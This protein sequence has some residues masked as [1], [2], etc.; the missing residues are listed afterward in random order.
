MALQKLLDRNELQRLQDEFCNVSGVSAYCLDHE[1]AKLTRISG[2]DRYLHSLPERLA[3]ERVIGDESLEDLAT[4]PLDGRKLVTALAI[5]ARGEKELYWILFKPEEMDES[6]Y[7]QAVELLRDASISFLQGKLLTFGAQADAIRDEAE[8]KRGSRN[9]KMIQAIARIIQLLDSQ[10]SIESLMNEWLGTVANFMELDTAQI[11]KLQEHEKFMDVICEWRKQGL[12]SFF[13]R[14]SRVATYSFLRREEPVVINADTVTDPEFHEVFSIGVK[15]MMLYPVGPRDSHLVVALNHRRVH[16]FDEEEEKFAADAVKILNNVLVRRIQRNSLTS[17]YVSMESVLDGINTCIMVR[18]EA[19]RKMIYV[20]HMFESTFPVEMKEED[21]DWLTEKPKE[22]AGKAKKAPKKAQEKAR[23]IDEIFEVY[24]RREVYYE[25]KERWY[26][27]TETNLHWVDGNV[28]RMYSLY[29]ITEKKQYQGRIQQQAYTDFL[30]GLYNRLCCE[31]DLADQIE[32]AISK[33]KTGALLY[34]DLDD[35]KHINDGL[36]HQYGDALL[37]AIAHAFQRIPGIENSCYR[38]G[39]DEFVIVVSPESY[40]RL[41]IILQDIQQIFSKPWFLKDSDYYCTMSMGAVTFP[42][43]G[44]SVTDLVKKADIAMY[45]AKKAGKNRVQ[46]Y[47]NGT[48]ST[49][50]RRL[51]MVKNMRE[52]TAKNFGEFE[53]YYQPIM[54]VDGG[55]AKCSGAEA[56]IRWN[57]TSLGFLSSTEFIPLAEY[58]GLINPIGNH[59][60]IEACKQCKE[61]N[62]KGYDFSVNVNLSVIQLLQNDIVD[63]VENALKQTKLDPSHLVLEVTE[64]LAINDMERMKRILDQIRKLGVKIALDDFGTG[65]SSLNH[66]HEI[67]FD[68][69]K[70]DQSFVKDLTE[71]SYF[72]SFIRLV[73]ELAETIGASI[74]VEGVEKLKQFDVLKSMKV[75]YIQGFYFDKPM[76]VKDFEE[77]Y[78]VADAKKVTEKKPEEKKAEEKK[79]EAAKDKK[80]EEKKP[81]VTKAEDKKSDD[82][83]A[84]VKKPEEKKPEASKKDEKKLDD[85]ENDDWDDDDWGFDDKKSL[86]AKADEKKVDAKKPEEKKTE[87]KKADEKKPAAKP[88]DKK[89]ASTGK[90]ASQAKPASKTTSTKGTKKR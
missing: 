78:C 61:W 88:D 66:V 57:S 32:N 90:S 35:F 20:N 23:G 36:G 42:D 43:N 71:D 85:F 65:Y 59:V 70:V 82:K 24:E 86:I 83:K 34:L 46:F 22:K 84:E 58:L 41:E 74:C 37:K 18:D 19:R 53:V 68:V 79:P 75:K 4:E 6:I 76:T 55:S 1:G 27:L 62:K 7:D 33:K 40:D 48:K 81:E 89:P 8:S 49:D 52:A 50:R 67:A 69:I 38:M 10:D 30:T 16:V 60:L 3:L 72:Q 13:D 51:D 15:A 44:D 5:K 31:R 54:R 77:K 45:A 2:D 17:A 29:D 73:S 80:A 63:I 11:F 21:F 26:D 56:L 28:V 64:S 9:A 39:G 47:N 25:K 12:S 14:T 87:G